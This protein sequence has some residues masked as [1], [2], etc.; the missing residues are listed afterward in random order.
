MPLS[1][2]YERTEGEA[3]TLI[4]RAPTVYGTPERAFPHQ[5]YPLP[6]SQV[7]NTRLLQPLRPLEAVEP[8][9]RLDPLPPPGRSGLLTNPLEPRILPKWPQ[10]GGIEMVDGEHGPVPPVL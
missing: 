4:L 9:A 3:L 2:C 6:V 1:F 10:D 7:E 5:S 8:G